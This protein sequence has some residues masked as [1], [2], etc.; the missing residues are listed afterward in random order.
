MPENMISPEKIPFR[1]GAGRFFYKK[2]IIFIKKK[3]KTGEIEV[4]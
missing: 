1:N 2:K 4:Y 3:K